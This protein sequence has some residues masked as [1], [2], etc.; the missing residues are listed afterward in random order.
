LPKRCSFLYFWVWREL[1]KACFWGENG[2]WGILGTL[3][4][5]LKMGVVLYEGIL[6][7]LDSGLKSRVG[8]FKTSKKQKK[9]RKKEKKVKK[10]KKM[11]KN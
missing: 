6:G 4:I 7:T 2:G 8:I 5:G 10:K 3:D 11:R 1:E 9:R